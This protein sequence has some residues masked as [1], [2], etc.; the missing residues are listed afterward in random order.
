[1][2]VPDWP[3]PA[4]VR[5]FA[6]TR[7]GGGSTGPWASLNLGARCGDEAARVADNRL[8]L[9]QA[10]GAPI[11]WLDQVHGKRV[12]GDEASERTADGVVSRTPGRV[13]A[14]LTADCL[15]ILLCD[16]AGTIVCA[17]HAGWRGLAAGIVGAGVAALDRNPIDLLVWLGPAISPAHFEVGQDVF[18]AFVSVTPEAASAFR[19]AAAGK[20]M[21]DL[22][23]LARQQFAAL[24]VGAVFGGDA[25]T[26]ADA[27]RFFSYR[28]DGV[29]GRMATGIL[30][31]P[32]TG[33]R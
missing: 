26:Y 7:T 10:I 8:R 3:A 13:C 21:A 20:W 16:R 9:T 18:D 6:T 2:I 27:S 22:Y 14:V 25:C 15:P 28:R 33:R 29:T 11:E 17:L 23:A 19:P 24:G 12:I 1:M 32:T 5:A 30:I 4:H 31:D